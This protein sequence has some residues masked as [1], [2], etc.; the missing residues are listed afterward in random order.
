[1]PAQIPARVC[2]VADMGLPEE[3]E[4]KCRQRSKLSNMQR[5]PLFHGVNHRVLMGLAAGC[6][7]RITEPGEFIF[8]QSQEGG[9]L[10]FLCRGKVACYERKVRNVSVDM[11]DGHGVLGKETLCT[12]ALRGGSFLTDKRVSCV[13]TSS[14]VSLTE[15][16]IL[17]VKAEH[18][19]VGMLRSRR[20]ADN[21]RSA[22]CSY[23]RELALAGSST[24]KRLHERVTLG[25]PPTSKE[26]PG[27]FRSQVQAQ[28]KQRQLAE[29]L[30]KKL[31][32]IQSANAA[33]AQ[34]RA[35]GRL[36]PSP[37]PSPGFPIILPQSSSQ[38]CALW[39]G[40]SG[41]NAA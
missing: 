19:A 16:E 21:I 4:D 30:Q 22:A 41:V 14:V 32:T 2:T 9:S 33:L 3:P 5:F 13:R 36:S 35:E 38:P 40:S 17:V 34:N 37:T 24:A 27:V 6:E 10:L 23:L 11:K 31:C 28:T 7:R 29:S 8:K 18:L 20:L 15:C 25:N 12:L 39:L 26:D 1:M